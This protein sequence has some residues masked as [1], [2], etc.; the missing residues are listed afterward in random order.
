MARSRHRRDE[1]TRREFVWQA[2]CAAVGATAMATTV[3]DLRMM[4]A[5]IAQATTQPTD[6]KALVCLFLFGG[7]DAGNMVI[8]TDPTTYS[9]YQT[10]RGVIAIP[11]KKAD[12]VTDNILPIN[13]LTNDGHTYGLHPGMPELQNLF[14]TG[15]LAIVNNV[16]T[17]VGPVT[18]AQYIA[19]GGRGPL[20]PPQLFSHNDQQVQWQTSVPDK[21]VRTGW[22]GR[23]AD[24]LNDSYNIPPVSGKKAPSMS[25][26][27]AGTNTW[28]VGN[29]V[30]LY[31]VGTSGPTGL[32]GPAAAQV[33]AIRDL[34]DL[35]HTNLYERQIADTTRGALDNYNTITTALGGATPLATVFPNTSIGNQL[36]MIAR[37]IQIRSNPDINHMRQI[38]FCSVGGYDLHGALITPHNTLLTQLS[39]A[40]NA[41]YNATVELGVASNVT[42]FTVSDFGRTFA[43]NGGAGSDHGW[44]NHQIVMGGAVNGQRMLGT[45]P[46]IVVNGPD[47]TGQGRWIPTTSVDEYSATLAKWFGVQSG[48][49]ATI[50]PNIGRFA[51]PDLGFMNA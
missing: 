37:L 2:A 36:K 14:N 50:F 49:M 20:F 48:N 25:I 6:Y 31:S 21:I 8:P 33:Q 34:I 5:A 30:S 3:W 47:D 1:M 4:N 10:A 7:N 12:G 40:M 29:M 13:P 45:F 39:Q 32:S 42:T 51:R 16:G 35:S 44:G 28:E 22:G 27:L 17:L 15:K 38:Y 26:S 19:A 41:F 18:R 46:T 11:L 24:L 43:V 9:Q 23:C